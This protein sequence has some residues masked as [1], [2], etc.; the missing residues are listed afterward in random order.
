M[1]KE[2]LV[3]DLMFFGT[4]D[5]DLKVYASKDIAENIQRK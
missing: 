4:S 2:D 5:I 1:K 3:M